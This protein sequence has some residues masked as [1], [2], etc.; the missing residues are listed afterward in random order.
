MGAVQQDH[1]YK[2]NAQSNYIRLETWGPIHIEDLDAPAKAALAL[3]KETGIDKLLD[4]IQNVDDSRVNINIQTKGV[5]VIWSL[6]EFKK[7]AIV[8]KSGDMG[9]MFL[10]TLEAMHLNLN[11]KFKGFDNETDAVKWLQEE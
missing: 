2:L 1:G 8:F 4:N 10:A 7:V 6:R 5:G 11:N 3:R 9:K